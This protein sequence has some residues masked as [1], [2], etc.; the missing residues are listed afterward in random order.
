MTLLKACFSYY[1][2][3]IYQQTSFALPQTLMY[4]IRRLKHDF[5]ARLPPSYALIPERI[6]KYHVSQ[7][8]R[9]HY[10]DNFLHRHRLVVCLNNIFSLKEAQPLASCRILCTQKPGKKIGLS[11]YF[12]ARDPQVLPVFYPNLL[13][14]VHHSHVFTCIW[15]EFGSCSVAI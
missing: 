3:H 9:L 10:F 2:L 1:S 7:Q 6:E 14:N 8:G 5:C 13:C 15:R 12:Y 11:F 4:P